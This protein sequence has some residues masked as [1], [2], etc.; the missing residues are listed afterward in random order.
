MTVPT[1]RNDVVRVMAEA[2]AGWTDNAGNHHVC[3]FADEPA[4]H[5]FDG[6]EYCRFHL[7]LG[8]PGEGGKADRDHEQLAAITDAIIGRIKAESTAEIEKPGEQ[9][10]KLDFQG[11]IVPRMFRLNNERIWALNMRSAQF[12]GVADFGEAQFH[13][14][15]E[16]GEAQFHGNAWFSE[17]QFHGNAA[18]FFDVE[19]G[20]P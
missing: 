10:G 8:K 2:C 18:I 17:A 3:Q 7:P 20:P 4:D 9:R 16:F 14:D 1:Q 6:K 11:V 12:L 5:K 19:G 13:G 15:A